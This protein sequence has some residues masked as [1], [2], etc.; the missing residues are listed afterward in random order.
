MERRNFLLSM[1]GAGA[2]AATITPKA[3]ARSP[4]PTGRCTITNETKETI[5]LKIVGALPELESHPPR[6]GNLFPEEEY[7]DEL[8]EGNR[9][10]I[11]WDYTGDKVRMMK[12]VNVFT[13]CKLT[14]Y[15]DE[16]TVTYE[17]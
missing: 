6:G 15:E 9:V 17:M 2:A 1:C 8:G 14:V 10:V 12:E 7:K 5:H 11:V 3:T 4:V 16:V 13:P